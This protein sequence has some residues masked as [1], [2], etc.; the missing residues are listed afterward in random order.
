MGETISSIMAE[1]YFKYIEKTYVKQWLESKEIT[2][3]KR[4]VDDILIIYDQNRTNEQTILHQFN[5]I[6]KN[7]QFKMST[8]E[9]TINYLD[10]YIHRNKT[11]WT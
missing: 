10:I 2:Y 3:N 9:N 5:K 1:V 8:E 6:D 4:Y 7:L 11:T